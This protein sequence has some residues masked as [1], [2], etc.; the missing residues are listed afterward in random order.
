MVAGETGICASCG[1]HHDTDAKFCSSCGLSLDDTISGASSG[2]IGRSGSRLERRQITVVFCDLVDSTRLSLDLDPED[3]TEVIREYRDSAVEIAKRWQGFVAR[4]VGDGILIYFGFPQ[5]LED[6]ASRAV[7][8]AWQLAR[9]VPLLEVG[10]GVPGRVR[11]PDLAVRVGV[12]TGLVIIGE[13]IGRKSLE[14]DGVLGA[15]PNVAAGLQLLA[16]PGEVVVSETTATLLSPNIVLRPVRAGTDTVADVNAF[17]VAHVPSEFGRRRAVT[18]DLFVGRDQIYADVIAE[19]NVVRQGTRGILIVGEPGVGKTRLVREIIKSPDLRDFAPISLECNPHARYSVL[20]PFQELLGPRADTE[21]AY[22][23]QTPYE[24]RRRI[25]EHLKRRISTASKRPMLVIEDMHWADFTTVELVG[26]MLSDPGLRNLVLLMTS[27]TEA[28]AIGLESESLREL[29]LTRLQQGEAMRMAHA[30]NE[31]S[32]LSSVD[33]A[34]IVERSDGIP[35]YIEQFVLAAVVSQ[36]SAMKTA[37]A[38]VPMTLR[39]SLMSRLDRFDAARTV[40]LT[41]SVLGRR[42]QYQYLRELIDM[43]EDKLRQALQALIDGNVLTQQGEY[44]KAN[45]E[46]RHALLHDTAYE[47]LLKSDRERLHRRV[48]VLSQSKFPEIQNSTPELLAMHHSLGGETEVAI[49]YWVMAGEI[50]TARSAN[51]EAVA[52][53][54]KGLEDAAAL[55]ATKP[56]EAKRAELELL[57]TMVG[58]LIGVS[59]WS[60]REL[61]DVY[62]RCIELSRMTGSEDDRFAIQRGRFNLFLLRSDLQSADTIADHLIEMADNMP[63]AEARQASLV[64][65]L[66][67]KGLVHFYRHEFSVANN[68]LREMLELYDETAHSSHTYRYG[69]EP[70]VVAQ[71]YLAWIHACS[72]Q[73]AQCESYT[74]AAVERAVAVAHPFSEAYALCFAASCAQL[75]GNVDSCRDFA[76]R[77]AAL[78]TKHNFQYWLAW[79]EAVK[80]WAIGLDDRDRGLLEIEQ[81]NSLYLKT[82][83]TLISPYF[84]ALACNVAGA[85]STREAAAR[86]RDIATQTEKSGV[87]FWRS[88][89]AAQS[90]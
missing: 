14:H 22:D 23:S 48:A 76:D 69:T 78:S 88:A 61:D 6:D 60:S 16:Q 36:K 81:A 72:G 49:K 25:F 75:L 82:G 5:A 34:V 86:R 42:F 65:A 37:P 8:A 87:R 35:L 55:V 24:R 33:I 83:S 62:T 3:L 84:N 11:R 32:V 68:L 66:R 56:A 12:N 10:S 58:P 18:P 40:A 73:I 64:E 71:S 17:V 67:A 45:F 2:A 79:A 20:Q 57:R 41:G 9:Q 51:V 80:G 30:M 26:E 44:P 85:K 89:L 4:Y 7:A 27:R 1:T 39:D 28:A 15:V 70:A 53:L 59:G 54:R 63:S 77:V 46:F 21:L 90:D 52:H 43:R 50:A 74:R 38:T 13:I 31:S 47:T 19:L 29:Q